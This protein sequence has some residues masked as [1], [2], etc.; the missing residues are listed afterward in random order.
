MSSQFPKEK[1][2]EKNGEI[3]WKE[4]EES[5]DGEVDPREIIASL[6]E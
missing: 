1:E 4:K 3:P 2:E 5:K 6:I